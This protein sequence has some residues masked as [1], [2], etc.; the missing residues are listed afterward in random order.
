MFYI[1]V[2]VYVSVRAPK[3]EIVFSFI[4]SFFLYFSCFFQSS[5]FYVKIKFFPYFPAIKQFKMR[6]KR[7]HSIW[8]IGGGE[9]VR[10]RETAKK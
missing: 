3:R 8:R 2:S 1:R 4:L 9:S 6:N 7:K 5:F 10:E